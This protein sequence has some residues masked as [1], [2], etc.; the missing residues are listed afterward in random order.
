MNPKKEAKINQVR[1]LMAKTTANG[2]TLEEMATALARARALMDTYAISDEELQLAKAE[3]AILRSDPEDPNDP[4]NIKGELAQAVAKFCD[5]R[6]WFEPRSRNRAFTFC[7]AR[8]DTEWAAWLLDH[9]TDFVSSELVEYL[10]TSFTLKSERRGVI[11]GFVL[12]TTGQIS[13]QLMELSKPPAGQTGN[14]RALVLHKSAAIEAKMK[15]CGIELRSC[16]GRQSSYD[17][18]AF[19]AGR[20]AGKGASFGRPVS[21]AAGLLR[22]GKG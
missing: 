19:G 6:A 9:L 15:E 7:G 17:D 11:K 14:G 5:C 18:G 20:K 21:G 10:M 12:G 16:R 22:L 13:D 2:C 8:S 4:H 3:A 1:A